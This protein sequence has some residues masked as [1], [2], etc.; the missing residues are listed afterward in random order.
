MYFFFALQQQQKWSYENCKNECYN[1]CI[2]VINN[3]KIISF[4]HYSNNQ[5]DEDEDEDTDE[6]IMNK[7]EKMYVLLFV[8]FFV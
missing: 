5:N 4:L 2:F 1:V 7:E 6:E 3:N 8:K